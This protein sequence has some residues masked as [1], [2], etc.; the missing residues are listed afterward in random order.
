M[1]NG[2]D[3]GEE[4]DQR[5]ADGTGPTPGAGGAERFGR[6][7]RK[8]GSLSPEETESTRSRQS[9]PSQEVVRLWLLGGDAPALL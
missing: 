5:P 3:R 6:R 8:G 9:L 7:V 1:D 4:W 2:L